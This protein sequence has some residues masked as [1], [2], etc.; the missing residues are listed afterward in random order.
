MPIEKNKAKNIKI[1]L[2]NY[3]LKNSGKVFNIEY[4]NIDFEK[5]II[6]SML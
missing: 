4:G 3:V 2:R 6:E 5:V 1:S